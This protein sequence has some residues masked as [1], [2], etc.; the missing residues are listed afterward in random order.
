M[1]EYPP[2]EDR[3]WLHDQLAR[4]LA[5]VGYIR[6]TTGPILEPDDRHFPD[7]F[8]EGRN[9]V[10]TVARRLL[11]WADIALAVRVRD[12]SEEIDNRRIPTWSIDLESFDARG[13]ELAITAR[14]RPEELPGVLCHVLAPALRSRFALEHGKERGYREA[15]AEQDAE[16]EAQLAAMTTVA[17][18]FGILAVNAAE[19]HHSAGETRGAYTHTFE[20]ATQRHGALPMV[21]LVYLLALQLTVRGASEDEVDRVADLLRPNQRSFFEEW[22]EALVPEREALRARLGI[23]ERSEWPAAAPFETPK[24]FRVAKPRKRGREKTEERGRNAESP[25]FRV[26]EVP[27]AWWTALLGLAGPLAGAVIAGNATANATTSTLVL[28]A[29][30]GTCIGGAMAVGIGYLRRH[31]RCSDPDC[32]TEI[33][34]NVDRCP[35]CEGHV[36]GRISDRTKRLDAAEALPREWYIERDLVPPFVEEE[37]SEAGPRMLVSGDE[38]MDHEADAE[39]RESDEEDAE[40]HEE[41]ARK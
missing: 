1:P 17:L 4:I 3:E 12:E 25:V 16:I 30:I 36:A 13:V 5:E 32:W 21:E 28:G 15:P 29:V 19:S 40:P 22:M 39:Q 10:R 38:E 6:F 8:V 34:R 37:H 14:G 35:S 23:P 24:P 41:R 27:M 11:R 18:G 33:P 2:E 7:V 26:T 20:V 31:D 9:G